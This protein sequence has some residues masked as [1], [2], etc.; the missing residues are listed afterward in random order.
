MLLTFDSNE[1]ELVK[2][3][4]TVV[5][6][7]LSGLHAAQVDFAEVLFAGETRQGHV[8]Q[9]WSGMFGHFVGRGGDGRRECVD[10]RLGSVQ[11][12]DHKKLLVLSE[13]FC[14]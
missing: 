2:R 7:N 9:V 12:R 13:T 1:H 11:G 6:H 8:G 10:S 5:G 14:F 4:R 3:Q